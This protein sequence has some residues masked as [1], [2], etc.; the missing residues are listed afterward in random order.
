MPDELSRA[1]RPSIPPTTTERGGALPDRATVPT[2]P[3]GPGQPGA[4][5][6]GGR[7]SRGRNRAGLGDRD[8]GQPLPLPLSGRTSLPHP[9]P[10]GAVGGRSGSARTGGSAALHLAAPRPWFARRPSSWAGPSCGACSPIPAARC[11]WPRPGGCCPR[12][13]PSPACPPARSIPN[14][15]PG[16]SSPSC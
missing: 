4:I 12:S 2:R 3:G 6:A 9:E 1:V 14:L 15:P 8:G 10:P 16:P 5:G 11:P 7:G 13:S